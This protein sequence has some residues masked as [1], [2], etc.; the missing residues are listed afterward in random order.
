MHLMKRILH[1]GL[2]AASCQ[3]VSGAVVAHIP[4]IKIAPRPIEDT[5]IQKAFALFP[6][7]SHLIFTSKTAVDLFFKYIARQ[8]ISIEVICRKRVGAIGTKTAER[9]RKYGVNLSFVAEKETLE[10]MIETL[11]K[12]NLQNAFLLWPRSS[13]SRT[14]LTDWLQQRHV[15]HFAPPF[16]DTLPHIPSPLPDLSQ[17]DEILFTSPSTVDAFLSAYHRFPSDKVYHAIGP[18]TEAHLHQRNIDRR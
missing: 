9:I 18:I 12:E 6:I 1:L 16:Y 11:E 7:V 13:L 3:N 15:E 2:E 5:G 10:G 4:F 14:V 8:D 17:F